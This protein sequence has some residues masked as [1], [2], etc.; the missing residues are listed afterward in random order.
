MMAKKRKI[1]ILDLTLEDVVNAFEDCKITVNNAMPNY[2]RYNPELSHIEYNPKMCEDQTQLLVTLIH[3]VAHHYDWNQSLSEKEIE[4]SAY[5]AL[6]KPKIKDYLDEIF[7][8][9]LELWRD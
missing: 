4:M 1:R 7:K 3:E 5:Y 9:D 6:L 8:G 2:G